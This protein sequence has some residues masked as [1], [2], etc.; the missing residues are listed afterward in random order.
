MPTRCAWCKDPDPARPARVESHGICPSC[1]D[2]RLA[3]L[4]APGAPRRELAAP[5]RWLAPAQPAALGA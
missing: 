1:L 2:Q 3:A 5:L 4:P